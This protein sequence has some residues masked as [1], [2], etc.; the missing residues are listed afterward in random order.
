MADRLAGEGYIVLAVACSETGR[1]GE[2]REAV[3]DILRIEPGFTCAGFARTQPF[4]DAD[5]LE[6]HV[7]GLRAAGLTD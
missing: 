4:Q 2:A 3:A 7:A 6:R 5:V 1:M